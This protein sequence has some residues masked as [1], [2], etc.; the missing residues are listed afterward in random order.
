MIAAH[1]AVGA[2]DD[3]RA[4]LVAYQHGNFRVRKPALVGLRYK[5]APQTVRRDMTDLQLPA[6][7]L[8]AMPDCGNN[9]RFLRIEVLQL[10]FKDV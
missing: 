8:D 4:A 1:V 5:V 3:C 10:Q 2:R 9:T 6:S 7:S